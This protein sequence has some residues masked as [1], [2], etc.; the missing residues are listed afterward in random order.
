MAVAPNG[1]SRGFGTILFETQEDALNAITQYNG[2]VWHGRAIEVREDRS[3]KEAPI[4]ADG[5][6]DASPVP[7]SELPIN[8]HSLPLNLIN[9]NSTNTNTNNPSSLKHAP[10]EQ[11]V[12]PVDPESISA[13][14]LF[15]GN[16][17]WSVGWQDLKDLFRQAGT[18]VRADIPVEYQNRS[19]GFG[20]VVMATV[21]DARKSVE[22][23]NGFDW[24]G[25]K[26]EVREDKHDYKTGP[27]GEVSA[28]GRQLFIGNLPYTVQWQELKDLFRQCGT[29]HRAD[30]AV[31]VQGRS[32]GY[33]TIIMAAPEEVEKAIEMLNGI[34]IQGRAIE[35]R[36]DKFAAGPDAVQVGTQVFVG[37]VS[38]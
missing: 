4:V 31:D 32:R 11:Y 13:R 15:V 33:G 23:F 21:E 35:V 24:N 22:M 29:V 26:I 10:K 17:P 5:D 38:S 18:V 37:N 1:R 12:N 3:A 34:T 8:A 6:L 19:R 14:N 27:N 2:H 16:L 36:E 28:P 7:L 30:V 25:R 9:N 20:T